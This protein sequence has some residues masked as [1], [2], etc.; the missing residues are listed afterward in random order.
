MKKIA[1]VAAFAAVPQTAKYLFFNKIQVFTKG[2]FCKCNCGNAY[3]HNYGT[4]NGCR[5]N[6]GIGWLQIFE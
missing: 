3:S 1:A 6:I 5:C 4:C 2:F